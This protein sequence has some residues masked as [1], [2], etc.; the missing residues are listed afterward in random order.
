MIFII[1]KQTSFNI[2][3]DIP[4]FAQCKKKG[5]DIDW[6]HALIIINCVSMYNDDPYRHLCPARAYVYLTVLTFNTILTWLC[7][8]TDL[9]RWPTQSYIL[10]KKFKNIIK[11]SS[12]IKRGT[13]I[14]C[15]FSIQ[16]YMYLHV[17]YLHVL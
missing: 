17:F 15:F 10:K 3:F 6:W 8:D 14:V 7:S 4:P 9:S 11:I 5:F 13:N 12:E 2:K 16:C 1:L